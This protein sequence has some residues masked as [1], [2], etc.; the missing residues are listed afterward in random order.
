M[1]SEHNPFIAYRA[2]V[3]GL[4]AVAILSVLGFHVFPEV[5]R[6]GFVGVDIFFVI[7]GYLITSILVEDLRRG[8]FRVLGFYGRRIRRLFPA[9]F[10]VLTAFYVLGWYSLV[11]DEFMQ[12]GKHM[13]GGAGFVSNLVL[14]NESGYFDGAAETK[15]FLHLWSLGVEEQFYLAWPIILLVA[16]K[17]NLGLLRTTLAIILVSFLLNYFGV[18]VDATATFYAPYTR[19]W[20]ILTGATLAIVGTS[21]QSDTNRKALDRDHFLKRWTFPTDA[22]Y[23][24][25]L[26][27]LGCAL[28]GFGLLVITKTDPFPGAWVLCPVIGAALVIAAGP[29][30]RLNKRIL[31]HPAIVWVGLVSYPLYLWHW[32][33]LSYAR[34]YEQG[35]PEL[36]ISVT[37]VLLSFLLAGLTR[38]FVEKPIRL[39]K[40]PLVATFGLMTV[41]TAMGLVGFITYRLDG[42][43]KRAVAERNYIAPLDT[44]ML[45]QQTGQC[46]IP[47]ISPYTSC[48]IWGDKDA[49]KK[50]LV[51]GDSTAGT[52]LPPFLKIAKERGFSVWKIEHQGCPSLLEIRK[53]SGLPFPGLKGFCDLAS[54]E[55][56]RKFITE[57]KPD[58]ILLLTAWN[59]YTPGSR[60][61]TRQFLSPFPEGELNWTT[62]ELAMK[63]KLPRTLEILSDIA[64]V[65]VVRAFPYLPGP[66]PLNYVRIPFLS[67]P[68]PPI[69]IPVDEFN[70]E[71]EFLTELFGSIKTPVTYFDPA[72]KLCHEEVCS[73]HLGGLRM[74]YGS[75]HVTPQ[76]AMAYEDEVAELIG[77]M[78][79]RKGMPDGSISSSV[80]LTSATISKK[81]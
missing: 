68:K 23:A 31:S 8:Q 14:W 80:H 6:G 41:M 11:P 60:F 32:P 26:S 42:L 33:L 76:G 15:P 40:R 29:N 70:N 36:W 35:R 20:E 19:F 64:S 54:R 47:N 51:W 74:Y 39:A 79:H 75:F 52:F 78:D 57:L 66:I 1:T 12:L 28:I 58:M 56:I 48:T 21:I 2:D 18:Q 50:L 13:A 45:L 69:T 7:S 67:R 10:I 46:A 44:T 61:P 30:A 17:L 81:E 72:A 9:L 38:E 4:R 22:R 37:V 73:S 3:D 62:T 24:T 55:E 25:V 43:D 71:S 5:F 53:T 27:S 63:E 34:I 49:S 59:L 16:H 65:G 77:R